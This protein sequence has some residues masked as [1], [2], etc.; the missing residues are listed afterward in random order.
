MAEVDADLLGFE[1]LP[2]DDD[3]S[4][5]AEDLDAAAAS[6]LA[7]PDEPVEEDD[8]PQPFGFSW[9]FDFELGRFRR[10]GT[11]PARVSGL[12]ALAQVCMMALRSARFG[13]T[14]FS[15]EFGMEDP[16]DII[17]E[18]EVDDLSGDYEDRVREAL[19]VIDRVSAVELGTDWDAVQGI[20]FITDLTVTTDNDAVLALGDL[21]LERGTTDG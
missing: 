14:V 6:S 5:P 1:L 10:Y 11:A 9:F 12:D 20:L 17:G 2:A 15:D 16:E 19:L 7:D 4:S 3:R 21:T 18:V 8:V 13:H